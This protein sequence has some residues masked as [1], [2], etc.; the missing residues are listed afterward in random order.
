M[1]RETPGRPTF[2]DSG[3]ASDLESSCQG[4]LNSLR[5]PRGNAGDLQD[6]FRRLIQAEVLKN[7][8]PVGGTPLGPMLGV[9]VRAG[10][11]ATD[12]LAGVI[13]PYDRAPSPLLP[14][15]PTSVEWH[16]SNVIGILL[17]HPRVGSVSA[18]RGQ[19]GA[20]IQRLAL[21]GGIRIILSKR[22]WVKPI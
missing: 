14:A 2:G 16:S 7:D 5:P 3:T 1:R 4:T 12:D 18:D 19:R 8:H 17:E 13:D 9:A 6:R 20:L 15:N 10:H 11:S 22:T 21:I